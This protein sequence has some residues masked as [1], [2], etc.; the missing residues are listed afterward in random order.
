MHNNTPSQDGY[1]SNLLLFNKTAEVAQKKPASHLVQN[2]H[3]INYKNVDLL[4][5]YITKGRGRIIPRRITG[6]PSHI[7]KKLVREIKIA[8]LLA[9]LPFAT[10]M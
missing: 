9:L 10:G 1:I 8:R 5:Q 7:H 2:Q 6:L 3:M 4:K